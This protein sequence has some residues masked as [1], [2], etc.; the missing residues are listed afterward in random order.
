MRKS[1]QLND[2]QLGVLR[3]I[4][5][6]DDVGAGSKTSARALHS[7]GLVVIRTRGGWTAEIT[8][9]GRFYLR[10]GHHPDRPCGIGTTCLRAGEG[11]EQRPT[12]HPATARPA[13]RPP[14]T[15]ARITAQRKAAAGDL[16]ARLMDQGQVVVSNPSDE[17]I[18][19]WR[20]VVDFAKRHD[21]V[22]AGHRI[23]KPDG[24]GTFT[25]RCIRVRTRTR[26]RRSILP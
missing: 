7:R 20:K 16:I 24:T 8:E 3:L 22:P 4:S 26:N 11:R 15:T 18:V 9:A 23:E 13:R 10:H 12:R 2:R 21:M 5:S 1:D 17:E 25:S 6:G 19:E 14:H